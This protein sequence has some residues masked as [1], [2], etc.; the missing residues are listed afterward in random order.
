[1]MNDPINIIEAADRAAWRPIEEAPLMKPVWGRCFEDYDQVV[2]H[3]GMAD[4]SDNPMYLF[5]SQITGKFVVV[6]A[7]QPLP[8][9][10]TEE[11][12]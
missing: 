5:Q 3:V 6:K 9:P 8:A 7:W 10:P 4:Y 12:E 11:T 2:I 1:M